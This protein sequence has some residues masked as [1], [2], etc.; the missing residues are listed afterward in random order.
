M[1]AK[2]VAHVSSTIYW[3]S[4]RERL[5]FGNLFIGLVKPFAFSFVIAFISC[6]KGFTAKGGTK[7]VGKA[8]M[9]SVVLTAISILV[10]NFFITKLLGGWLKGYL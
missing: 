6:Y 3:A 2:F 9:E 4:I 10:V 5:M 8:T 7:G 1:V